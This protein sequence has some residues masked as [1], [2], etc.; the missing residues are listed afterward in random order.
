MLSSL[1]NIALDQAIESN[2]PYCYFNA[3]LGSKIQRNAL[4]MRR[5][6]E[7]LNNDTSGLSLRFQ[8]QINLKTNTLSGVEILLRWHDA[9]L[10]HVSPTDFEFELTETGLMQEP[11]QAL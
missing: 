5:L 10:G 6:E 9:E 8:P 1:A 3:S 4:M 2:K 7:T 11:E